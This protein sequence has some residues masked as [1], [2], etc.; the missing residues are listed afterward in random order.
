MEIGVD[1]V[2]PEDV[3]GAMGIEEVV[4]EGITPRLLRHTPQILLL[5]LRLLVIHR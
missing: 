2:H 4:G 1:G 5:P 3:G